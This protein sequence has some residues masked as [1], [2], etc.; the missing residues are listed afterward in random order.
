MFFTIS[1]GYIKGLNS[2]FIIL[3]NPMNN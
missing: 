1:N 3:L 2:W